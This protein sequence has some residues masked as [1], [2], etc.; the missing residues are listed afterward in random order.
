MWHVTRIKRAVNVNLHSRWWIRHGSNQ[1]VT[2]S[3]MTFWAF[4]IVCYT[5][6]IGCADCCTLKSCRSA[7]IIFLLQVMW[8]EQSNNFTIVVTLARYEREYQSKNWNRLI[9]FD[10]ESRKS[11][12]AQQIA[13][14][15][16]QEPLLVPGQR[17]LWLSLQTFSRQTKN[18]LITLMKSLL[19]QSSQVNLRKTSVVSD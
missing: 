15:E 18:V 5:I 2:I 16:L 12:T 7:M 3:F 10:S 11:L 1:A 19:R 17:T 13:D 8:K 4:V 14:Q 6:W 9:F